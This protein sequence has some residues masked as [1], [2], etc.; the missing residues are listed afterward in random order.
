MAPRRKPPLE[1]AARA[2]CK[3]CGLTEETRFNGAPMWRGTMSDAMVVLEAAL[4]RE[5]LL[6]IIPDYPFPEFHDP[7]QKGDS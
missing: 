4:P 6:E 5:Q 2:L 1:L 7:K 3:F